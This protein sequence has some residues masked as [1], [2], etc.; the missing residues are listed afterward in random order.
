MT[1][2]VSGVKTK[3]ELKNHAKNLNE[4]REYAT[5]MDE[6][7][8]EALLNKVHFSDP[9]VMPEWKGFEGYMDQMK[10]GDKL[11]CTNHPKRS[12]FATVERKADG[13]WRVS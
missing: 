10:P 11:T 6:I 1:H 8:E 7:E 3:T 4:L 12:W 5:Y 9:A 2:I 13:T